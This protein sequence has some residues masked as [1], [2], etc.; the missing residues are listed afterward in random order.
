[1]SY[2]D[3]FSPLRA[4]LEGEEEFDPEE[5]FDGEEIEEEEEY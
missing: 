3:D 4:E 2:D 5:E 1:M